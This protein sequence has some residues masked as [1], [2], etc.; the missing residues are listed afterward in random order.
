MRDGYLNFYRHGQSV[1]RVRVQRDGGLASEVHWKYVWP[2]T[3]SAPT[4]GYAVLQGD[5]AGL[6]DLPPVTYQGQP[7]LQAWVHAAEQ[8]AGFEKRRVDAMVADNARVL[9]VEIGLPGRAL[10]IDLVEL[11]ADESGLWLQCVEVKLSRDKRVRCAGPRPEVLDQLEDYRSFLGDQGNAGAVAR[12]YGETARVLVELADLATRAGNPVRLDP[13]V[14]RACSE[15][16]QVRPTVA[17]AV[18]VDG[19][20]PN[21]SNIHRQKLIDAGVELRDV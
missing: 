14:E 20:D 16:I 8:Y 2:S 19:E 10:R 12:A 13:L 18:A 3:F 1:A 7:T 6:A 15:R 5:Q 9:D 11:E 21:W 17:L 4:G